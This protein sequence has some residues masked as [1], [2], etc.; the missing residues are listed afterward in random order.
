VIEFLSKEVPKFTKIANRKLKEWLPTTERPP[1]SVSPSSLALDAYKIILDK[2]ILQ[3]V[4]SNCIKGI[5]AV[6]VVDD[7]DGKFVGCLS[8][9]DIKGSES[10]NI[11][12]DLYL[13]IPLYLDKM[14][15]EFQRKSLTPITCH[16]NDTMIDCLRKVSQSKV[17]RLFMVNDEGK[18]TFVLSLGD[19]IAHLHLA[20]QDHKSEKTCI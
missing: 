20:V 5:S 9:S 2:V 10:A 7:K 17:H 12:A 18:T 3:I 19:F 15:E 11:F 13:P 8:G 6:A 16:A 1:I 4:K 14:T